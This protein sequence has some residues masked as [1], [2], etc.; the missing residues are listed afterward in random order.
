MHSENLLCQSE[1][2]TSE[3][4]TIPY[5]QSSMQDAAEPS[6]EEVRASLFKLKNNKAPGELFKYVD[7][8][9]DMN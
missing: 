8:Q 4:V 9:G 7:I 6:L 5:L 3:G 2:V 1:T